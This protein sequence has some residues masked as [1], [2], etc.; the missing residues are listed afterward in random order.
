MNTAE[1]E[2]PATQAA[3]I[4]V[5]ASMSLPTDLDIYLAAYESVISTVNREVTMGVETGYI[6]Y[7]A[8]VLQK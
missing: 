1:F 7:V 2:I 5:L 3:E 6:V 8:A 4:S